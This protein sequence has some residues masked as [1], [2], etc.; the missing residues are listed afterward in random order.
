MRVNLHEHIHCSQFP[1]RV[2][3]WTWSNRMTLSMQHF[4]NISENG[5]VLSSTFLNELLS[6]GDP[7][8]LCNIVDIVERLFPL[9]S[10]LA[11][12]IFC[13][14]CIAGDSNRA[15]SSV[16]TSSSFLA[17]ISP[18]LIFPSLDQFWCFDPTI[19]VKTNINYPLIHC[20][21]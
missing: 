2:T 6:T 17:I 21:V 7:P 12:S 3:H 10:L 14:C 4:A 15:I 16:P 11:S 1:P 20:S 5:N 19:I 18:F 8:V 9:P 13:K